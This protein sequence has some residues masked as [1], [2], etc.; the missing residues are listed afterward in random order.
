MEA[1]NQ[2]LKSGAEIKASELAL[3][4]KELEL[5][6]IELTIKARETETKVTVAEINAASAENIKAMEISAESAQVQA[7]TAQ[8]NAAALAQMQQ[9][10]GDAKSA[11]GSEQMMIIANGLGALIQQMNKPKVLIKDEY[12]RPIGVQTV[13]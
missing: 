11:Q 1:E 6:E 7:E 4:A 2:Q 12:G 5:K 10:I 13:E 8:A 3:R 9:I